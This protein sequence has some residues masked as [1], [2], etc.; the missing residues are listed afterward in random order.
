MENV[1]QQPLEGI[2]VL[3]LSRILAAPWASQMLGD[4]GADVIK[5]ERPGKGDDSRYFGPPF[6]RDQEGRE[7]TTLS[8]MFIS[9]NR[10]KRSVTIDISKPEGQELI[11]KLAAD[12]DILLENYKVGDLKRYGLDYE[13]LRQI[14]PRLIYCSVTGFGQTG[15][16]RFRPGYDGIF[17]A[18]G[19]MMSTTGVA[20]GKPGAGPMKVGVSIGDVITGLYTYSAIMT[21]LYHRDQTGGE[22][23][24]IDIALLDSVIAAMS[25]HAAVYLGTGQLPLR[26][27]TT[28]GGGVPAQLFRCADGDL[29]VVVGNDLQFRQLCTVLGCPELATDERFVQNSGRARHRTTLMPLLEEQFAK[30][31]VDELYKAL[32]EVGVPAGPVNTFDKVFA[33]PQVRARGNSVEVPHP[34][35]GTLKLGTNPIHFSATPVRKYSAPPTIGQHTE[36][37]LQERLG[38]SAQ[39]IARLR[40]AGVI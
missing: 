5:V 17:Q 34:V 9:A 39:D 30:Q 6:V 11:R 29:M 40:E 12:S 31:P 8:P 26:L 36:E 18:M 33:D 14:N 23:Q 37:I 27:G 25:H 38:L 15:P 24:H 10:N 19:G 32:E 4:F 35:S 16:Y 1:R 20:D 7:D 21:A 13:S 3:D 2:R 28:G 22:G